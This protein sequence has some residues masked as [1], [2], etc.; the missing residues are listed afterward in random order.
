MVNLSKGVLLLLSISA[1]CV[2]PCSRAAA[3][4]AQPAAAT[5]PADGTQPQAATGAA[6]A[7]Q[8]SNGRLF[9]MVPDFLTVND[10][11]SIRPLTVRQ[12]YGVVTRTAF[13]WF[14]FGWYT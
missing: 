10:S 13:D 11:A 8:T 2:V 12:K 5:T 4:D 9:G 1:I 6:A 7:P 3:Q 14:Q